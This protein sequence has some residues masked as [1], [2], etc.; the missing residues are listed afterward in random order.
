MGEGLGKN[1][2]SLELWVSLFLLANLVLMSSQEVC[3][4]KGSGKILEVLRYLLS[5]LSS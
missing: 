2:H 3:Y 1:F 4:R 5:S